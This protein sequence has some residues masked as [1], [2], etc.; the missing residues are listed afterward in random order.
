MFRDNLVEIPN[1]ALEGSNARPMRLTKR[2]RLRR[3]QKGIDVSV[4]KPTWF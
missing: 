2:R 3:L 1:P 4:V